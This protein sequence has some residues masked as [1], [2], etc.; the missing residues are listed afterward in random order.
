[1]AGWGFFLQGLA[2]GLSTGFNMVQKKQEM[3]WKKDAIKK[4]KELEL[5]METAS[6]E[7]QRQYKLLMEDQVYSKEDAK[8]M[9]AT[10]LGFGKDV[11]A[12]HQDW[13]KAANQGNVEAYNKAIDRQNVALE[14]IEGIDLSTTSGRE[15][16]D[17]VM[18]YVDDPKARLVF[19]AVLRQQ[20]ATKEPQA[21]T[22]ISI[23]AVK[24]KYGED[25]IA[26]YDASLN[27]YVHI[28]KAKPT[29]LEGI[30]ERTAI[31]DNIFPLGQRVFDAYVKEK[32]IDTTYEIYGRD[33]REG[34]EEET[35]TKT[36]PTPDKAEDI[37]SLI[38]EAT[39]LE[40][41]KRIYGNSIRKYGDI[42][43]IE[44]IESFYYEQRI[45]EA[46]YYAG[47][48]EMLLDEDGSLK[49]GKTTRIALGI[50]TGDK[51]LNEEEVTY[52]DI[53]EELRQN[54][55]DALGELEEG[56]ISI[57]GYK[58]IKEMSSI[59]KTGGFLGIGSKY[60]GKIYK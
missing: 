49:E 47:L 3:K 13:L 50:D 11:Y 23:Q 39:S 15:T 20:A 33:M 59:K 57:S 45:N 17:I 34:I 30:Q 38:Q 58:Q 16:F 55:Y 2:G 48:F 53:L 27:M 26:Q 10:V 32:G 12:N 24:D 9:N 51:D 35:K 8:Y 44:D 21:E 1:M 4:G 19:E 31:L 41:A 40:E 22:F 43:G 7:I 6:N 18:D 60:K 52:Y 5:K 28:P 37:R 54:Y 14:L 25:A 46:D 56:L 42:L 36:P 29:E